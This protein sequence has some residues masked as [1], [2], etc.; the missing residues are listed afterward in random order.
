MATTVEQ[1]RDWLQRGLDEGATHVIIVCDTYDHSDYPVNVMPDENV[2][3]LY[4]YFNG[5]NMQRVIEV[6]NLNKDINEQLGLRRS[7]TF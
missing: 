4:E 3:E 2:R 7:F 5:N 6:Y 1:I